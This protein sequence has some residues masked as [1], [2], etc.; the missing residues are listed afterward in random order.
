MQTRQLGSQGLTVSA[1]GL[2]CMGITFGYSTEIPQAEGVKL[3]RQAFDLGVTF[4]DTAE[5]YGE[6]NEV[7]VGKA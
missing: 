7:L 6:A 5:A 2:G 4:F 1:L 3:I